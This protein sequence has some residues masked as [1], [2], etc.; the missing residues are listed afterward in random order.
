MGLSTKGVNRGGGDQGGHV[1]PQNIKGGIISNVFPRFGGCIYVYSLKW[2]PFFHVSSPALCVPFFLACLLDSGKRPQAPPPPPPTNWS[3]T[4]MRLN[5]S[6]KN[7]S[8]PLM[9]DSDLRL[10]CLICV[11]TQILNVYVYREQFV[12]RVFCYIRIIYRVGQKE[13]NTYDH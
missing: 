5:A 7:K 8:K 2:D 6:Q 3:R 10:I 13:C 1:P 12:S 9:R 11:Q 4:H